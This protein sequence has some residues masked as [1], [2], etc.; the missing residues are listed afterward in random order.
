MEFRWRSNSQSRYP[1]CNLSLDS[2]GTSSAKPSSTSSPLTI[3]DMPYK[4][5]LASRFFRLREPHKMT[6]PRFRFRGSSSKPCLMS[7][8]HTATPPPCAVPMSFI[9]PNPQKQALKLLHLLLYA[10]VIFSFYPALD[11]SHTTSLHHAHRIVSNIHMY[12]FQ[13][14][15]IPCRSIVGGMAVRDA[16]HCKNARTGDFP[17]SILHHLHHFSLTRML[18]ATDLLVS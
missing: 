10:I 11:Y 7:A 3:L 9:Q 16:R 12:S 18:L 14:P 13:L 8:W 15:S 1:R 5:C 4:A 17:A 6:T 2:E